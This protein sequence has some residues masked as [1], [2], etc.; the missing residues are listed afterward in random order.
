MSIV[1][2]NVAT[3]GLWLTGRVRATLARGASA[4]AAGAEAPVEGVPHFR[5]SAERARMPV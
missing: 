4:P 3:L 1:S 2:P 5:S